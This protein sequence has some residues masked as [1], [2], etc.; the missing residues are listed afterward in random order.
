[1]QR[2]VKDDFG[3][4]T[5]FEADWVDLLRFAFGQKIWKVS[6]KS[7]RSGI[8]SDFPESLRKSL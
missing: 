1:L 4:I 7:L 5:F 3:L 8:M 2:V 6:Y